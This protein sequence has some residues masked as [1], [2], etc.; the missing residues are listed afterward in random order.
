MI[1]GHKISIAV[2]LIAVLVFAASAVIAQDD[3]DVFSQEITPL[4]T[5]DCAR[6]HVQ[7]F[8]SLRDN[9]GAHKMDCSE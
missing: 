3:G 6:C 5:I 7:A 2:T 1:N 8:T 4:T 9:G